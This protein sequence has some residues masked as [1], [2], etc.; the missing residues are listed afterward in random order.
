M[1]SILRDRFLVGCAT[2]ITLVVIA[3]VVALEETGQGTVV[4]SVV[5]AL[6][7]VVSILIANIAVLKK[8][9]DTKAE[10][11]TKPDA[12]QVAIII[13]GKIRAAIQSAFGEG[14]T[15]DAV[16]SAVDSH[17]DA[18]HFVPPVQPTIQQT[19][20]DRSVNGGETK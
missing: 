17:D 8:V 5:L 19:D 3:G 9:F 2:L 14:T 6:T 7:P 16:Q 4:R 10:V 13:N 12:G 15:R 11:E 1:G 20:G 18:G